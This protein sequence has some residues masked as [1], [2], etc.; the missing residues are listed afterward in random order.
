MKSKMGAMAAMA[1]MSVI[2]PDMKRE[3]EE[4]KYVET[5]EEK[6]QRMALIK[7]EQQ[8]ANGLKEF[9]YGENSIWAI[10]KKNAD[11]KARKLNYIV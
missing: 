10:N 3:L 9:T 4:P 7:V 1:I 2:N 5:E 11:K 6:K 8:K